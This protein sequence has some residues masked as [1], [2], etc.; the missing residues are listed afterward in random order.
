MTGQH[1]NLPE[2]TPLANLW[3]TQAQLMGLDVPRFAD[4]TGAVGQLLK[5]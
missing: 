1:L 5:S 4:S 2:G 3:L